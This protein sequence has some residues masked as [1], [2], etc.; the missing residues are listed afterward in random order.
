V[1]RIFVFAAAIIL[2]GCAAFPKEQIPKGDAYTRESIAFFESA[3]GFVPV[4]VNVEWDGNVA[5]SVVEKLIATGADH[6]LEEAG[7]TP[8]L[9]CDAEV[10][11]E[12]KNGCAEVHISSELLTT[13]DR[14][15]KKRAAEAVANT[16]YAIAGVKEV[17]VYINGEAVHTERAAGYTVYFKTR[18]SGLLVPVTRGGEATAESMFGEMLAEPANPNLMSLFSAETELVSVSEKAG[19]ITVELSV[20]PDTGDER[21]ALAA[22]MTVGQIKG[23]NEVRICAD[24]KEYIR[25]QARPPVFG[26]DI[27]EGYG[28]TYS[29]NE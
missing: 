19:V 14:A 22:A 3:G 5:E 25:E 24:G 15:E 23:I 10:E 26:N 18:D 6:A 17:L 13:A 16:L 28:K 11:A 27:G 20:P 2:T 7:L 1:K 29:S 4:S 21:I 8:P 12:L 9:P